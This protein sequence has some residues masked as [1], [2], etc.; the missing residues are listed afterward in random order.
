M[1]TGNCI[2]AY[3][4]GVSHSSRA[5]LWWWRSIPIMEKKNYTQPTKVR[6]AKRVKTPLCN[7]CTSFG[8]SWCLEFRWSLLSSRNW[9]QSPRLYPCRKSPDWTENQ[10]KNQNDALDTGHWRSAIYIYSLKPPHFGADSMR[11]WG[12]NKRSILS[13]LDSVSGQWSRGRATWKMEKPMAN[14]MF[15]NFGERNSFIKEASVSARW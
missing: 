15:Q 3:V 14:Y 1:F 13:V 11:V 8:T 6:F 9:A 12:T 7:W 10:K 5:T 2:S 4:V